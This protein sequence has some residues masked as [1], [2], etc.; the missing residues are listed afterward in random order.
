MKGICAKFGIPKLLQSPDVGQSLDGD[1]S[2]FRIFGQFFI[3]EYCHNNR[4]SHDIDMKL[5]PVNK[6]Y[7]RDTETSKIADYD[8]MSTNCDVIVFFP[9]FS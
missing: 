9:I 3:N 5:G 8:V 6:L 7:N 1:I 2:D 4:T